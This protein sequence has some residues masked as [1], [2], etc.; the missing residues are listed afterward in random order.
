MA[1]VYRHIR[2]DKNVPFYI[3]IGSDDSFTRANEKT[4]R[5]PIWKKIVSKTSYDVEI[6]F[7]NVSTE[8]AKQKEKEF[9][10]LY[11][12]IDKKNGTLTNLTDGGDGI[13]GYV[14]TEEHKNKLSIKAKNRILSQEQKDK[15]RKCRIGIKNSIEARKKISEFH[16]NRKKSDKERE[17]YSKRMK[18]KNPSFILKR[19]KSQHFKGYIN[20]YKDD[21]FIGTYAGLYDAAEKLSLCASKICAV[22]KGK[23]NHTKGYNFQ[24]IFN[25]KVL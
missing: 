25:G 4:R 12:R 22:L 3:G 7:E 8:F 17:L 23:R 18:V 16:K 13:V 21:I 24:R 19:E 5:N 2:H 11:G 6:I 9:I 20:A 10:Q 15:L 1:Y 14:F